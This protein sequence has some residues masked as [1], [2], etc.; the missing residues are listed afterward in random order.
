MGGEQATGSSAEVLDMR[1]P[2]RRAPDTSADEF[3]A[4][5]IPLA[6]NV[7]PSELKNRFKTPDLSSIFRH[8]HVA[9]S[10]RQFSLAPPKGHPGLEERGDELRQFGAP[11]R[12]SGRV[13]D[14]LQQKVDRREVGVRLPP[15]LHLRP[16]SSNTRTRR[17]GAF[18]VW[19]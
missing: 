8:A 9:S 17:T 14:D 13:A 11:P 15:A 18:R 19:C 7:M 5:P 2:I 4:S 1:A 6:R 16:P 10:R 12:R 3:P